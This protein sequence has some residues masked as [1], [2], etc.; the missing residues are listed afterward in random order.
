MKMRSNP[1]AIRDRWA[2]ASPQMTFA[3]FVRPARSRFLRQ[4]ACVHG[5]GAG[6]KDGGV[7]RGASELKD[8]RGVDG[9]RKDQQKLADHRTNNRDVLRFG[10]HLQSLQ[11]RVV[12]HGKLAEIGFRFVHD[13]RHGGPF[14]TFLRESRHARRRAR[15][16]HLYSAVNRRFCRLCHATAGVGSQPRVDP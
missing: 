6:E 14:R 16:V 11:Q 8:G 9:A 2:N 10:L 4:H 13:L 12:F 15:P 5:A 1:P 3:C 7:A